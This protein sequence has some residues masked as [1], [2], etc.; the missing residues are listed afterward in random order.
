MTADSAEPATPKLR[1]FRRAEGDS[2]VIDL[3]L[4]V[5]GANR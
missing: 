1:Q 3:F 5:I 2:A 4:V